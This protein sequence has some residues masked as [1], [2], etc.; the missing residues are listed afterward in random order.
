MHYYLT[1]RATN[2]EQSTCVLALKVGEAPF[3]TAIRSQFFSPSHAFST[4]FL[5]K[6]QW[7]NKKKIMILLFR[8]HRNLC[9]AKTKNVFQIHHWTLKGPSPTVYTYVLLPLDH[10]FCNHVSRNVQK[11]GSRKVVLE[12]WFQ[13]SGSAN[14]DFFS[15]QPL[16]SNHEKGGF[17]L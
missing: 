1:F 10:L 9:D 16:V 5:F 14:S 3:L 12:K 13:K 8:A 6:R 11:S 17:I 2:G 4:L 7:S 15:D